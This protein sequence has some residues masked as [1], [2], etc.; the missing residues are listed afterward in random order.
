VDQR[1]ADVRVVL[2][3]E[4][5]VAVARARGEEED[6]AAPARRPGGSGASGGAQRRWGR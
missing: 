2:G 4:V 6:A 1:R 5:D 3:G